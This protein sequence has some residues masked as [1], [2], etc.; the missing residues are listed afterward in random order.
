MDNIVKTTDDNVKAVCRV[1]CECDFVSMDEVVYWAQIAGFKSEKDKDGNEFYRF[2]RKYNKSNYL[3]ALSK[4]L[5]VEQPKEHVRADVVSAL[6]FFLST[7]GE[8]SYKHYSNLRR[9]DTNPILRAINQT[10][11]FQDGEKATQDD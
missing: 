7:F 1:L 8:V 10:E 6:D 11:T 2:E 4:V 5:F 9:L 3:K